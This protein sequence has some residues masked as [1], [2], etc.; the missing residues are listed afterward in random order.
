MG[1][2][3]QMRQYIFEKHYPS[4]SYIA[5]NWPRSKYLLKK[6]VL[7][8]QKKPNFF[9]I[10]TNCLK[11]LNG[12]FAF[13]F[14]DLLKRKVFLVRDRFGIKPLYFFF[15]NNVFA[16]ASELKTLKTLYQN[17]LEINNQSISDYLSLMY[18]PSPNTIF[19]NIFKLGAG[20][21]IEFGLDD[22][23]RSG[24]VRNYLVTKLALAL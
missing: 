4:L 20:E 21:K 13:C 12:M 18:V 5:K 17:Q 2:E 7:S 15:Q 6:F 16:F 1:Y 23:V 8:N 3:K 10:C 24:L 14:Y 11:D 9:N 19:K 22:I